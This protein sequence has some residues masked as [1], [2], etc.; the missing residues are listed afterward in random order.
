MD[1]SIYTLTT[2]ELTVRITNFGARVLSFEYQGVD[3][4][5]G[6][7]TEDELPADTCYCGS[8]CGRVG[9]PC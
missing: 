7:K 3:C 5:Y 6:P 1:T 4:L 2:P 9:V 8:I